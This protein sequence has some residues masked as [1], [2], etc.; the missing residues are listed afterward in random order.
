[1]DRLRTDPLLTGP[2][3][4]HLAELPDAGLLTVLLAEAEGLVQAGDA[5][6]HAG[7]LPSAW[8]RGLPETLAS[9]WAA[10]L[11]LPL[12][13]H[14]THVITAMQSVAGLLGFG[15]ASQHAE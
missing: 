10:L 7:P 9:L 2:P 1:M 8:E 15:A 3:A 12:D 13:D 14:I 5:E 11:S 6:L 4:D